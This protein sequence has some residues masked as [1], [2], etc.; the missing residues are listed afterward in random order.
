MM[1]RLQWILAVVLSLTMVMGCLPTALA[2]GLVLG[3]EG[4]TVKAL[5]GE[6]EIVIECDTVVMAV[7][8]R[9]NTIDLTGVTV[10][11]VYTGDCSG[12]RT[13]GILEA[14]RGGYHAANNL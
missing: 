12:E 11:V 3:M 7:G 14:I 4:N 1:K 13:A 6:E 9:K 2:E 5:K 10:P 8:S